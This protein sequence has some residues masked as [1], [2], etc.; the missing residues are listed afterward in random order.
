MPVIITNSEET[1]EDPKNDED[2]FE[3]NI[4]TRNHNNYHP[5]PHHPHIENH[6]LLLQS[7]NKI[8]DLAT[9]STCNNID[10]TSVF[11]C[12]L[13]PIHINFDA[14]SI[15][16]FKQRSQ[17]SKSGLDTRFMNILFNKIKSP[18]LQK[19]T[20]QYTVLSCKNNILLHKEI[21]TIALEDQIKSII[22]LDYDEF[23]RT[24]NYYNAHYARIITTILVKTINTIVN[25]EFIFNIQNKP[26]Q[27]CDQIGRFIF[28]K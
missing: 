18:L 13:V 10:N 12:K 2:N 8:I 7:N 15:L 17:R 23:K 5:H 24:I 14:F 3:D 25:I 19:I 27:L 20:Q 22:C 26:E 28:E 1:K 11:N 16:F 21:F 9:I 4:Q 6:N